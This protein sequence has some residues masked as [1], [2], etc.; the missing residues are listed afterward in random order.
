MELN[1]WWIWMIMA[2]VF[3]VGEIFTA[4]FFLLCVWLVI[5]GQKRP[6]SSG[7]AALV[8]E[9]GRVVHRI[10]GGQEAGKVVFHGE[11]WDAV[12]S[13]A[14]PVNARVRVL[15]VEGRL[16]RVAPEPADNNEERN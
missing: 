3:I 13:E 10:G 7:P 1:F 6:V 9:T 15:N 8:G 12:A 2:A 5:R 16:A 14:I 11:V 4:G